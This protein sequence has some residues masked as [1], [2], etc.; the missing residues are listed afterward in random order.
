MSHFKPLP[1]LEELQN[2]FE[3]NP[4]TG[5]FINKL[6]RSTRALKGAVAGTRLQDG[7]TALRVNGRGLRASR[8]AWYFMTGQDPLDAQVDHIDRVRH[9]DWWSNLR[10]STSKQNH[11]NLLAKGFFFYRGKYRALMQVDGS[12]RYLGDFDTPEKARAAY[13][14]AHIE[15][16]GSFSP[17]LTRQLGKM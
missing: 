16:Y 5:L 8:V 14:K 1:P 10:L 11:G 17:Y 7:Y 12:K 3:Y 13:K 9:H 2:L 6:Q 15:L 4:E